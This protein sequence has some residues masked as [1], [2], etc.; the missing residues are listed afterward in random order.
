VDK[1]MPNHAVERN[2]PS[3]SSS[4]PRVSWPAS[5]SLGRQAPSPL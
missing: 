3:R 5:L 1:V 2:W 4:N